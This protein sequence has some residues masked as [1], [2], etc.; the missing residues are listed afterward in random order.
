MTSKKIEPKWSREGNLCVTGYLTIVH[1][2]V[3]YNHVILGSKV[4]AQDELG[5]VWDIS[6]RNFVSEAK[7]LKYPDDL[8]GI[9]WLHGKGN[10]LRGGC[11]VA[12][13]FE[14]AV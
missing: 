3:V 7:P 4:L 14:E 9:Y 5:T 1:T 12:R 6:G 2:E 13:N 8:H 11:G 10:Y